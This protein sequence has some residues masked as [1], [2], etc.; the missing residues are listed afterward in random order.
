MTFSVYCI[1][2]Q[3]FCSGLA[4]F[5][6]N[7]NEDIQGT[8]QDAYRGRIENESIFPLSASWMERDIFFSN[9]AASPSAHG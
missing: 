2:V 7:I 9:K 6:K 8:I 5:D 1:L 4:L 3:L